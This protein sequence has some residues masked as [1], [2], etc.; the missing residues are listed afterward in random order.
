M[1]ESTLNEADFYNLPFDTLKESGVA[2]IQ[3]LDKIEPI[4]NAIKEADKKSVRS[5]V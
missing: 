1:T 2:S 5:N 3:L 4:N